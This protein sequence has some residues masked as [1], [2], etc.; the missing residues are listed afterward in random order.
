MISPDGRQWAARLEDGRL[1][2]NNIEH[3]DFVFEQWQQR[4]GMPELIDARDLPE[5]E[6]QLRCDKLGCVYHHSTHVVAMP[7][8]APAALEDC[9]HADIVIAPFLIKDCAAKIIIDEPQ[10][11][12]HGAHTITFDGDNARVEYVR[13]RRGLRPWSPGY[14]R[15]KAE[16]KDQDD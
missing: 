12:Q 1:A 4:L 6:N 16:E 2:V 5:N 3:G 8:L 9:A 15:Q 11:W 7:R 13:E 14:R 10:F